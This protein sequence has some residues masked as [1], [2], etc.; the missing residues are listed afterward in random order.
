MSEIDLDELERKAKRLRREKM[1]FRG[2]PDTI[3]SLIARV[4]ELEKMNSIHTERASQRAAHIKRLV[5]RDRTATATIQALREALLPFA[6]M[7]AGV[8]AETD[9]EYTQYVSLSGND[10]CGSI[11]RD[12]FANAAR[13]LAETE[14]D[15]KPA[16]KVDPDTIQWR[17]GETKRMVGNTLVYRSYEDYCDD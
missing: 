5:E 11:H 12:A 17:D 14:A 2:S 15:E 1:V 16:E 4:R 6:G 9:A 10:Y 8:H 3:V 7:S 13:A